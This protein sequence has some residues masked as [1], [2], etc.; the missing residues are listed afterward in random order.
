MRWS[1]LQRNDPLPIVVPIVSAV[2]DIFNNFKL[3]PGLEKKFVPRSEHM[4]TALQPI[5]EDQLFLGR[6]YEDLFDQFEIMLALVFADVGASFSPFW[7]PPGRF[8]YSELSILGGSKPYTAFVE[9]V[10]RQGQS[11]PGLAAGFFNGSLERFNEVA[12]GFATLL[13]KAGPVF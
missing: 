9:N 12:E 10:R 13:A 5:I 8:A 3:M 11:W 6:S 7:G 1:R 4:L 2:T